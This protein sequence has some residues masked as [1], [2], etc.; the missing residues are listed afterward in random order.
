MSFT[1]F[2]DRRHFRRFCSKPGVSY[3]LG[4]SVNEEIKLF[5]IHDIA[6]SGIAFKFDSS[7]KDILSENMELSDVP[8]YI[9]DKMI[10]KLNLAIVR[11]QQDTDND[12]QYL[13][14]T[15]PLDGAT[16]AALWVIIYNLHFSKTYDRKKLLI[17]PNALPRIPGRGL[18]TE[19]A[20]QE[21]LKFVRE[22]TPT[23]AELIQNTSFD[24][25]KLTGNIEAFI[26]SVEIPLG[27]A[28]PLLINGP[29]ANGIYYAPMATSEGALVASLTRGAIA[30]SKSG[31]VSAHVLEQRMLRVPLF[32]LNDLES[33]LFFSTWI[34]NHFNE[35]R[36]QT[37]K[38]SNYADLIELEPL[39][40]GKV[41][42]VNFVYET[43]DAAGQ[44]MTTTCTW[45][46]CKWILDQMKFFP[47]IEIQKFL[48]DGS[49]SNDKRVTHRSFIKGRG[50]R[51]IAEVFIPADI[52]M[53][54]LKVTPDQLS[55]AY[56]SGL[57]GCIQASMVGVNVNVANV[58]A[59]MFAACGQDIASVH[60]S[61]IAHF[62][63]EKGENGIYASMMLP[64]LVIGTVGGGTNLPQQRECLEMLGCA[65]PGHAHKLAEIIVSYCLA[66]DL[67]TLSAIASG[68]FASAHER[69]GRNRPIEHLKLAEIN[70]Q[71]M[72]D[73]MQ[74]T[75][76]DKTIRVLSL[77]ALKGMNMES[78]IITKFTADKVNKLLGILPYRMEYT[79][80][81][82]G[83]KDVEVMIK[84][85]PTDAEVN[86]MH[87]SL[88][89]VCDARLAAE[90]KKAGG[91][92]GSDKCHIKELEIYRQ[93]DPRFVK[94]TPEI[95][96][97]LQ[98]DKREAYV[99]IQERLRDT[100]LM[101]SADDVSGWT[102]EHIECAIDGITEIHS[103]WYDREDEL[104]EKVWIG[105]PPNTELM[106][107]LTRLWELLG[108]HGLNEFP[109]WFNEADHDR[110]LLRVYSIIGWWAEIEKMPKTLIHNDF[111]PRNITFKKTDEGLR[112]CVYDWELAT[113]HLP[114]HDLA[115]LLIF[116]L[117]DNVTR[118]DIEYYTEYQRM[119]L[120]KATGKSIDKNQWWRGFRYSNWDLMVNRFSLYIMAH[121]VRDYGFIERSQKTFRKILGII[122]EG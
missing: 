30:L 69:L 14:L 90:I 75:L 71:F 79:S 10:N 119:A 60:E 89:L 68:Q 40:I 116:V 26:G 102:R 57:V 115:E 48:I 7:N 11:I 55:A 99:V 72:T 39:V 41:V 74:N 110:F 35:I 45:N 47:N 106:L 27:I 23:K 46:T 107:D 63:V 4:I 73:I 84:I 3:R 87:H 61:S 19:D 117:K 92:I 37:K 25:Q 12:S 67:S 113:I 120:E 62:H 121:T 59:A 9:N 82:D 70:E 98:D 101:D 49:L 112:L 53:S 54:V 5:E 94:H 29:N 56:L 52:L 104:K 114:Q 2:D 88:G 109:E 81:K 1:R 43:G 33:A 34:R 111:N 18:Y 93:S 38:Y 97:I 16:S 122:S 95:F 20:R 91:K 96:G 86:H 22:Q 100:V 80:D 65:G 103:I 58:I 77:K 85:K 76:G 32:A 78:S 118:E 6:E 28:G 8:I 15:R 108:A 13:A 42:H 21:R 64:S 36:E 17:D 44:N 83:F 51:V 105:I 24:P 50:I 66:L 31:G